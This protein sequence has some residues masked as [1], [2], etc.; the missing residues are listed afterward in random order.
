MQFLN[1]YSYRILPSE[2]CGETCQTFLPILVVQNVKMTQVWTKDARA[3]QIRTP[4]CQM[5]PVSRVCLGV[6]QGL[7]VLLGASCGPVQWKPG[8][9]LRGS[10]GAVAGTGRLL[11]GTENPFDC[12]RSSYGFNGQGSHGSSKKGELFLHRSWLDLTYTT[13]PPGALRL[14]WPQKPAKIRKE[15]AGPWTNWH[16]LSGPDRGPRRTRHSSDQH[17]ISNSKDVQSEH[18]GYC[19]IFVGNFCP[20]EGNL[21]R[22]EFL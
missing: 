14:T 18:S 7:S 9:C 6:G 16:V 10:G 1:V 22:W 4:S 11:T 12:T 15:P 3:F 19:S 13:L 17:P 20:P 21:P 8:G 5:I 2:S